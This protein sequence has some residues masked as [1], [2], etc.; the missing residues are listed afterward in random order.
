MR[1]PKHVRHCFWSY[2][3]SSIDIAKEKHLI[4]QQ[5]LNYGNWQ[6]IK[7]LFKV[8]ANRDIKEVLK[9][10]HRGIWWK[11][12]L[13]FWLTIFNL[14]IPKDV[15]ALAVKEIDPA[16]IDQKALLRFFRQRAKSAK[17]K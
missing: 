15:F 16:K 5:I 14:H 12:V 13:N 1:L 11:R 8:Y 10:P 6:A 17:N 9:S 2:D 7:W 3:L 4:I